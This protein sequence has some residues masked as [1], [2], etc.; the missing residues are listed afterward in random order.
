V[1]WHL[2]AAEVAYILGD[3][4]GGAP[5]AGAGG[6]QRSRNCGRRFWAKARGPSLASSLA[7]TAMPA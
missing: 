7:N 3:A 5:V 1:N 6:I 4:R 2:A